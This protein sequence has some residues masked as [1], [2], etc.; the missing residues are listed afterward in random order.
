MINLKLESK[1]SQ[2][3]AVV[4]KLPTRSIVWQ[5]VEV[6]EKANLCKQLEQLGPRIPEGVDRYLHVSPACFDG[7][8]HCLTT[9]DG[10]RRNKSSLI[11]LY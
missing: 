5:G 7:L 6:T 9:L 11:L 10:N 2:L 4:A 8:G 1:T 3:I